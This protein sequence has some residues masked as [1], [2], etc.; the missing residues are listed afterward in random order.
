MW[1]KVAVTG[2]FCE[3]QDFF[4][5]PPGPHGSFSLIAAVS[6]TPWLPENLVSLVVPNSPLTVHSDLSLCPPSNLP[7]HPCVSVSVCMPVTLCESLLS[8][9]PDVQCLGA[10]KDH[11]G[12]CYS[13][14]SVWYWQSGSQW[15]TLVCLGVS[16]ISSTQPLNFI[17]EQ[18]LLW[19]DKNNN[20]KNS[21]SYL[22]SSPDTPV[23]YIP[24]TQWHSSKN[25]VHFLTPA[26]LLLFL[27]Q[28]ASLRLTSLEGI[29]T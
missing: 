26:F 25:K 12:I 5:C 11:E 9:L 2:I 14:I 13:H 20:I 10:R 19:V 27:C 7:T 21:W 22:L 28:T 8:W 15:K 18:A 3:I 1:L 29:Q 23:Q 24:S 16:C 6:T 17:T 4:F